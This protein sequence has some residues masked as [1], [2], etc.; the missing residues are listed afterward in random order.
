MTSVPLRLLDNQTLVAA[1]LRI[2]S[3]PKPEPTEQAKPEVPTYDGSNLLARF[4]LADYPSLSSGE[5]RDDH[6]EL[7][8]TI[9]AELWSRGVLRLELPT[10][11][12]VMRE[13][14]ALLSEVLP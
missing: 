7:G 14:D 10:I 13:A 6:H 11:E 3:M 1:L 9:A 4:M 5:K 2:Q 8:K 12:R